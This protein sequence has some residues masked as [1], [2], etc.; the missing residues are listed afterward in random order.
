MAEANGMNLYR[1]Y[2]VQRSAAAHGAIMFINDKGCNGMPSNIG[3]LHSKNK[4]NAL[5]RALS[6][7]GWPVAVVNTE[8]K[9]D[10]IACLK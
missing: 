2:R 7:F 6:E 4:H 9:D 10:S 8:N 3:E 5:K 1:V